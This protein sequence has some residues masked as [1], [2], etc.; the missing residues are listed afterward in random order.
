[1]IRQIPVFPTLFASIIPPKAHASPLAS[2]SPAR[3]GESPSKMPRLAAAMPLNCPDARQWATTAAH[4]LEALLS[5]D[6]RRLEANV[7]RMYA[8]PGAPRRIGARR[9]MKARGDIVILNGC[10]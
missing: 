6:G 7:T 3:V 1:M 5:Q 10:R 9:G 4:G 8:K 2:R